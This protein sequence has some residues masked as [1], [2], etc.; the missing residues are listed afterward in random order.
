M[1][2]LFP[3]VFTKHLYAFACTL[4]FFLSV[5]FD[6]Y[7]QC[8]A[9]LTV[10]VSVDFEHKATIGRT[11]TL[12]GVFLFGCKSMWNSIIVES[13]G[14][15]NTSN[16][17]ATNGRYTV[18]E[19]G[20]RA[21]E[22]R[23]NATV[24]VARTVFRDNERG[25]YVAP[26]ATGLSQDVNFGGFIGC[27]FEGTGTLK[28]IGNFCYRVNKHPF[29][30]I[31]VSDVSYLQL[32]FHPLALQTRFSNMSNGIL[33]KS[34]HLF[35]NRAKFENIK[36]TYSGFDG[37]GIWSHDPNSLLLVAGDF[38]STNLN[39]SNCTQGIIYENFGLND[40]AQINSLHIDNTDDA[41]GIGIKAINNNFNRSFIYANNIRAKMGIVSG[42]N[43]FDA[44]HVGE[45]YSNTIEPTGP[46]NPSSSLGIVGFDNSITGNWNIYENYIDVQNAQGGMQ[47][48]SGT[49]ATVSNNF[50]V[51]EPASN[52]NAN[53]IQA[54]G[55]TNFNVSCN[56][57]GFTGNPNPFFR[58][59]MLVFSG[60]GSSYTC[61]NTD[62]TEFGL[63]TV[64]DCTPFSMSGNQFNRHFSG[65]RVNDG[66]VIGVQS[67]KGNRWNGPF[68]PQTVGNTTI[69]FGAENLNSNSNNIAF[70]RFEVGSPNAPI[71]PTF[72]PPLS[73]WFLLT[74]GTDATCGSLNACSVGTSPNQVAANSSNEE[75]FYTSAISESRM[76]TPN[77]EEMKWTSRRNA[78]G[79]LMDNPSHQ[80]NRD[81]TNFVER[82]RHT[83]TG[84]L[85]EVE[86]GVKDIKNIGQEHND[87]LMTNTNTIKTLASE[88]A[89]LEAKIFV[90]KEAEKQALMAQKKEKNATIHRLSTDNSPRHATIERKRNQEIQRLMRENDRISTRLQPEINEKEVNAIYLATVAQ[91]KKTLNNE[92]K[93]TIKLIAFQCPSFG[94]NAVFAARS[95]YSLVENVNFNDLELCN[96]RSEAVQGF[97]VKKAETNYKVSPNPATDV[98]AVSQLSKQAE[99][100]EWLIFNTAGKLLRSQKVSESDIES[101]INI[102]SLSEGIYFVSFSVNGQKRF[103]Q[104]LIKIKSN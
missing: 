15:L 37:L 100:G 93:A 13:G 55:S 50:I 89:D 29:A 42:W 83:S 8:P 24:N 66:S 76:Q 56:D 103:T 61:N 35:V 98:L 31:D 4:F 82:M 7:A 84:Q 11:L 86:K 20:A 38:N 45:I 5:S 73:N 10:S 32:L 74:T 25:I 71:M 88:I 27:Q 64:G 57:I 65:L 95:L 1:K 39:F 97:A 28:E 3:N 46:T 40:L 30:G 26:S 72:S 19:D 81:K 90:A 47:F 17:L 48:N 6:A 69:A 59:S 85:Y 91:G 34:T 44:N 92:Q 87:V 2:I 60:T 101:T 80:N 23:P 77:A 102:Q 21:I 79:Q 33:A 94:G 53:G 58:S 104:K 18:I 78:Y 62:G 49:G 70:S 43:R 54:G 12:N 63:N 22:A 68:T 96:V 9:D 52:A 67:L 36:S 14:T 16:D 41:V 75:S 51:L 99:S